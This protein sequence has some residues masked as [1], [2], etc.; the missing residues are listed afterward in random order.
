MLLDDQHYNKQRVSM[1][2]SQGHL[3]I[4]NSNKIVYVNRTIQETR[5]SRALG[6]WDCAR[7]RDQP[8]QTAAKQGDFQIG[9]YCCR[10]EK[11]PFRCQRSLR[12]P[13]HCLWRSS[14]IA[15]VMENDLLEREKEERMWEGETEWKIISLLQGAVANIS[16]IFIL[17]RLLTN[18]K[19]AGFHY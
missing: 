5:A 2:Q 12:K 16:P 4:L 11:T 6:P 18:A 13:S 1:F 17:M 19:F 7:P 10:Q 8:Y 15:E 3:W 9:Y 14:F